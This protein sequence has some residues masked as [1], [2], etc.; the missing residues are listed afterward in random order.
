MLVAPYGYSYGMPGFAPFAAPQDDLFF[1]IAP[2]PPGWAPAPMF[3]VAPFASP[4]G[5]QMEPEW[6]E[7]APPDVII[8]AAP[9]Q[10]PPAPGEFEIVL[11]EAI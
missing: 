7:A 4:F 1:W 10:E 2:I 6:I 11:E 9:M 8:E 3:H 5:M